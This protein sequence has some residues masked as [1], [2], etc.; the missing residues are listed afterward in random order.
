MLFEYFIQLG[1]NSGNFKNSKTLDLEV[2]ENFINFLSLKF[3]SDISNLCN[4]T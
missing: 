2:F 1:S 4:S 3:L